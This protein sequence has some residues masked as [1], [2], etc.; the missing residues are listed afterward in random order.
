MYRQFTSALLLSQLLV[1]A[2]CS[3]LPDFS[4][5]SP[6]EPQYSTIYEFQKPTWMEN[7][8]QRQSG[9][10]L[11]TEYSRPNLWQLDPSGLIPQ[12]PTLIATFPD[13]LGLYG[14]VEYEP[15][16][17]A[18]IG[19]NFTLANGTVPG[20][21]SIY[22]V[23]FRVTPP[24]P[25]LLADMHDAQFLNGLALLPP[26]AQS[27]KGR[28]L[29]SDPTLGSVWALDLKSVQQNIV[30]KDPLMDRCDGELLG[31]N[32]IKYD[33]E[34]ETIYF[35]NSFCQ[36]GYLAKVAV[37]PTTG[38]ALGPAS[39]IG[40]S[41][42]GDPVDDIAIDNGRNEVLVALGTKNI[43]VAVDMSTGETCAFAGNLNST[44]IANPTA[45]YI[46]RTASDKR[47]GRIYVTTTGGIEAPI[48]G[49]VLIGGQVVAVDL[50]P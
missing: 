22:S 48:N 39:V 3:P 42:G 43:I 21:F 10:L 9:L 8:A 32:G 12:D 16:V 1:L 26:S 20:S 31:I 6:R 2:V 18:V 50:K 33:G 11:A 5:W 37:D 27:P 47:T 13:K 41:L 25:A 49:T 23:D 19:G 7:I 15:E 35:T 4:Q 36:D 40:G 34:S 30:V 24:Q 38:Q 46:G 29:A 28:L 45:V 17:F 14:I 44:E